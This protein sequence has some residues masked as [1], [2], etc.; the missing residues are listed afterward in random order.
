MHS[1]VRLAA[2][3]GAGLSVLVAATAC[4]ASAANAVTKT[5][6]GWRTVPAPAIPAGTSGALTSIAGQRA[7]GPWTAGFTIGS[8]KSSCSH[9]LLAHWN[10]S[11]W[12][13]AP[14]PLGTSQC[15]RL[16]AITVLSVRD[17]WGGRNAVSGKSEPGC[18]GCES[19]HRPLEWPSVGSRPYP[20]RSRIWTGEPLRH[21]G[22]CLG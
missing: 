5:S 8:A 15:G 17:A 6:D 12:R 2:W 4:L 16:E 14:L 10:G 20:C 19:T 9:P 7:T 1:R 3:C 11:G 13:A 18:S 21:S 22:G